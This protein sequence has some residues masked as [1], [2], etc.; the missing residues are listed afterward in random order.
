MYA[1]GTKGCGGMDNDLHMKYR[2][3]PGDHI[4]TMTA[5]S[6]KG[7]CIGLGLPQGS[8]CA[9]GAKGMEAN[10]EADEDPI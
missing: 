10:E 6:A 4:S 8:K 3:P 5:G 7:M 2:H 1:G 9:G